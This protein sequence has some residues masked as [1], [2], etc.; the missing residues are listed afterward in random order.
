VQADNRTTISLVERL[1]TLSIAIQSAKVLVGCL[2]GAKN[3]A[4]SHRQ[5]NVLSRLFEAGSSC[6]Y[7]LVHSSRSLP[8]MLSGRPGWPIW[9]VGF[10][11]EA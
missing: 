5:G 2:L 1:Q 10:S 9:P 6:S 7:Y 11:V 3:G 8:T 4:L